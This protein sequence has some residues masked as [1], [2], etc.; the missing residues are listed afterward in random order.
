MH[1]SYTLIKITKNFNYTYEF[2]MNFYQDTGVEA[3][4]GC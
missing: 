1:N 3:T 4:K 2:N